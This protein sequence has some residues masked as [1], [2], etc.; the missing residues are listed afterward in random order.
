MMSNH[1]LFQISINVFDEKLTDLH[2]L[3]FCTQ[4]NQNSPKSFGHSECKMVNLK[5]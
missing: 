2:L 4:S 1:E 3:T 5:L